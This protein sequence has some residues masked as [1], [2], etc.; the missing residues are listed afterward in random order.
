MANTVDKVIATADAEIGY[1][2]KR[3][4]SQLYDKTANA[5]SNNYT[6]YAYELDKIKDFFNGPKNGYQWCACFVSWCFVKAY[7]VDAARKMLYIPLKS[8]SAGCVGAVRYYKKAG[9]F[10]TSPKVGDQIFF[11][12]SDG[13]PGHTGIVYKVDRTYVY[14]I[15]GNTSG[16]SGVIANGGGV[17]KKKYPLK[18]SYIYG[19]GRPLYDAG[20]TAPKVEPKPAKPAEK[21]N[22]P[23]VKKFQAWLN[24]NYAAGLSVNGV[25]NAATK[26]AAIKALQKY[27][28]ANY[29]C[30]LEVDG[31]FGPKTKEATKKCNVKKGSRNKTVYILQGIL[32]G[33]EYACN[34]FDGKCGSGCKDAIERFQ[35]NKGLGVDGICGSKTWNALFNK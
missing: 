1:L 11:K 18:S 9:K 19:Y 16:A 6:K 30:G 35:K 12:A 13:E 7:G 14:T 34:G 26:K 3:T 17:C 22:V 32:Y 21:W 20:S 29:G 8:A 27:L 23:Y 24:T 10:Y 25:Y 2:E 31:E 4:N 5:G 28:N 33:R 15:E